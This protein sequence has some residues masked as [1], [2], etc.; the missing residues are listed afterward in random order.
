MG[1]LSIAD[2]NDDGMLKRNSTDGKDEEGNITN[3]NI[4]EITSNEN[5]IEVKGIISSPAYVPNDL[6]ISDGALM[7]SPRHYNGFNDLRLD[8]EGAIMS[9]RQ[10]YSL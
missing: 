4:Y 9:P 5:S 8:K 6:S 7:V 3:P 2:C 10:F 1:L